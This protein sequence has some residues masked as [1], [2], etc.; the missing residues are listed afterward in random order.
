LHPFWFKQF[1][2]YQ[3]LSKDA[4]HYFGPGLAGIEPPNKYMCIS[5]SQL[6]KLPLAPGGG[7]GDG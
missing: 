4:Q 5:S 2:Y 7:T 1:S 6:I 3:R